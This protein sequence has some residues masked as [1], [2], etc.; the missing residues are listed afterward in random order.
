MQTKTLDIFEADNYFFT[1]DSSN[2][3]DDHDITFGT[4]LYYCGN[5]TQYTCTR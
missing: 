4:M 1:C 2:V 3:N 5:L